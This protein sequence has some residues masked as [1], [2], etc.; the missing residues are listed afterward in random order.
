MKMEE[1]ID[2]MN[3][4]DNDNDKKKKMVIRYDGSKMV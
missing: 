2:A 1:V 3:G 4:D